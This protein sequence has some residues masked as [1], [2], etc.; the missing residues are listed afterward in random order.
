[1][2][3]IIP[4]VIGILVVIILVAGGFLIRSYRIGEI[5]SDELMIHCIELSKDNIKITGTTT[6]SAKCYKDFTYTIKDNNLYLN[7]RYVLPSSKYKSGDFTIVIP[8]NHESIKNIYL[9]EDKKIWSSEVTEDSSEIDKMIDEQKKAWDVQDFITEIRFP[10]KAVLFRKQNGTPHG[11]IYGLLVLK[12]KE[13]VKNLLAQLPEVSSWRNEEI[14]DFSFQE[15][16]RYITF[17]RIENGEKVPY[18]IDL[19][20]EELVESE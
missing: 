10:D 20:T 2:K 9:K 15:D 8:E 19:V 4:L 1:M 12:E 3:K 14:T 13:D 17:N 18:K 7:I 5:V 11:E 16:R 6:D